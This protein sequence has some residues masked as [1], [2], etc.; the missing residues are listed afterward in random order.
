MNTKQSVAILYGFGEGKWHGKGLRAALLAANFAIARTPDNANIIIAHSGGMYDLP[1]DTAGKIVFLIA[2]SC[3]QP[4]KTWLET[5]GKKV[6]Q[7]MTYFFRAGMAIRW[8][9]KSCWNAVY[10]VGQIPKLPRLW[11]IHGRHQA[12]LPFIAGSVVVITFTNDPWS[13]YISDSEKTK[14]LNYKFM[15]MDAIHDDVW[16]RPERYV[17]LVEKEV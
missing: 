8:I 16:L 17:G 11:R 13:G 12:G 2:P 1:K 14:H 3:G 4:R 5:Q 9:Q 15:R 7:D 6:W 10:L